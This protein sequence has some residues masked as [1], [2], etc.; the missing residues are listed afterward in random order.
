MMSR[1]STRYA[2]I[3]A[4]AF[5]FPQVA[6][7]AKST[8]KTEKPIVYEGS[9]PMRGNPNAPQGGT[10]NFSIGLEP[11]TLNP[12]TGTDLYNQAVQ[13]Y[14]LDSLMGRDPETHEWLPG[15]AEKAEISPDGK[16][17]TFWIRKN[18]KFHDGHPLTAEDVKF[19]FD[20]VFD[21]KYNAAHMRPYFENVDKAEIIDPYT[22]KFTVKE[23]YFRNFDTLCSMAILPKHFYGDAEAGIKKNKTIMGSGSYKLEK[24]DQGQSIVFVRNKEWWGNDLPQHKGQSNFERVRMRFIKDENIVLETLKKGDLDFY[25]DFKPEAYT[26][27]A[28]G[29]E[30]GKTAFKEKVENLSPKDYGYIGWNL[31]RPLFKDREVR[32]ALAMLVNR[33]EMIH[34]FRFDMS[35]PA[36]GPTYQQSDYADPNVKPVPYDPKKAVEILKKAGWTDSDKDGVLD[37]TVDG[38]K[39]DFRFTLYYGNKD[40]EKYWVM[41]QGDLKRVGIDMQ[42]QL[43]EWNAMMKAVDEHNFDAITMRWG[44]GGI[45]WD[46][47]QVWHSASAAKGG[48]NFISYKNPEVDKLIDEARQELDK[49]KRVKILRKVY[50]MIAAD[51]PYAFLF[52]E[53][54]VLYAHS[55][56][57][58]MVKPTYKYTIGDGF[59]WA[60]SPN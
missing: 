46:P 52:N 56:K 43:I 3:L 40:T 54:Y 22:V 50:A 10:F 11:S 44:S 49:A 58:K 37:K 15:L 18:A 30:W 27:K 9:G 36:T 34:K 17:F 57:V 20:V 6:F 26:V 33:P 13:S 48:S 21:P 45:D 23:K 42:L 29:P 25:D 60:A 5:T 16:T 1:R 51:Y 4:L 7:S 38:K 2:W 14:V 47:K 41:Y 53:R 24:Y 19:S 59:W 31:E 39:V 55:N 28:T 32:H 35:L 12:I 8:K